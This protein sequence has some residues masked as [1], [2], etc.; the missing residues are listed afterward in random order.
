MTRRDIVRLDTPTTCSRTSG[1]VIQ[2][3]DWHGSDPAE[4]LQRQGAVGLQNAL[5]NRRPLADL[6]VDDILRQWPGEGRTPE[7]R[8]NALHAVA[9]FVAA[10]PRDESARQVA[11]ISNALEIDERFVVN[12]VENRRLAVPSD[13]RSSDLGL[14][15]PP[16]LSSFRPAALSA[17][18]P[19]PWSTGNS[20]T[21]VYVAIAEAE[22]A[23]AADRSSLIDASE[24]LKQRQPEPR[25]DIV[26]LM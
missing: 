1:C 20:S 8:A 23:V 7:S 25:S 9:P 18:Q 3:V 13:R 2:T 21:N 16:R 4:M 11:R 26:P 24:P 17:V 15:D 12:A 10:L 14:P 5:V 22:T 6:V 19:A